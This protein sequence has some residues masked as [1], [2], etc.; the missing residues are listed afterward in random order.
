MNSI[1]K[2]S[3]S[4]LTQNII[5]ESFFDEQI[6]HLILM[7]R[8]NRDFNKLGGEFIIRYIVV[9]CFNLFHCVVQCEYSYIL[10]VIAF[11]PGL[12]FLIIECE[13]VMLLSEKLLQQIIWN[14]QYQITHNKK[15]DSKNVKALIKFR[16][17]LKLYKMEFSCN[18]YI[19]LDHQLILKI[20]EMITTI[21]I[22]K[23]QMPK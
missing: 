22:I 3:R 10:T 23:C 9:F 17:A 13:E 16:N 18:G 8:S 21:I 6:D 14:L 2:K 20:I 12:T 15:F 5:S 4:I 19:N 7:K 11:L 1:M